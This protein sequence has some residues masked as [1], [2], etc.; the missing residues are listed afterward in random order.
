MAAGK[1]ND[2]D[3]KRSGED[4]QGPGG[5][6]VTVNVAPATVRVASRLDDPVYPPATV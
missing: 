6:C 5:C 4:G 1:L 3:D 2:V